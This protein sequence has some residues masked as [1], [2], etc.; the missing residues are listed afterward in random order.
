MN[1][2]QNLE[3][4]IKEIKDFFNLNDDFVK[5][6]VLYEWHNSGKTVAE[7][8]NKLKP[9]T[10]EDIVNFYKKTDAYVYDLS[11]ESIR[12]T[13][14]EW[15]DLIFLY[16]S[17]FDNKETLLDF[18]GGVGT[19]S[20]FFSNASLKTTY[21]DLPSITSDFARYRVKQYANNDVTFVL[22]EKKLTSYD[23]IVC[24][25]VLEHLVDPIKAMELIY[26]KLKIGGLVFL[27]ESFNLIGDDYPSHLKQNKP[28]TQ[29]FTS[30]LVE[31]GFSII[32]KIC[33]DRILVLGKFPVVDLVIPTHNAYEY[34]VECI[35]SV[36][37]NTANVPY[38]F[39]FVN[40]AST[41]NK[42]KKF[43]LKEKRETDLY[44]E[45][46]KNLGFVKT[47]NK[48]ME[49]SLVNDVVLLNTDTVVA[50]NWLS[51][52]QK[53][54]YKKNIY[55]TANPLSNNASIYSIRDIDALIRSDLSIEFLGKIIEESSLNVN[56][57][58]PVGVGFCMYIKRS[59]IKEVGLFDEVFERGYGEESDYC[60]RCNL[61]GYK[62]ILVDC[63]FVYHKG[64]VS[65]L[66]TG[67]IG[68]SND[69]IDA[70]EQ[71]IK[72]RY[73]N[74]DELINSFIDNG[75][76]NRIS[77][78][79]MQNIISL[80]AEKRKKI[81]YVIHSPI[82]GETIGGTEFHVRDLTEGLDDT[83]AIYVLYIKNGRHFI[84][85]EY[86]NGVKTNYLFESP[87]FIDKLMTTNPY[88]FKLYLRIIQVFDIDIVHIQHLINH[89]FDIINAAKS[90]G[91][92]VIMTVHDYYLVSIDYNLLYRLKPNGYFKNLTP[93]KEYFEDK[94]E[95][96]NFNNELWQKLIRRHLTGISLFIFPSQITKDELTKVY[97]FINN[98]SKIIEHGIKPYANK[99]I[100]T[101]ENKHK[102]F[103]VLFLGYV[104]AVQKGSYFLDE[105]I[106]ELLNNGIEVHLLG[107][108]SE[109]WAKYTEHNNFYSHGNYIR[110]D[111]VAILKQINPDLII[112]ASPW[113]ETYSYTYSEALQAQIPVVAFEIGAFIER[114][115]NYG[116]TVLV[117]DVTSTALT[118]KILE[119]SKDNNKIKELKKQAKKVQLKELKDNIEEYNYTYKQILK[120]YPK[121]NNI[122]SKEEINII[123]SSAYSL[124]EVQNNNWGKYNELTNEK[125]LLVNQLNE[126]QLN[127][128]N[129]EQFRFNVKT[130]FYYKVYARISRLYIYKLAKKFKTWLI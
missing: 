96:S 112:L 36:K 120:N 32:D 84:V 115:K 116:A 128:Q 5:N 66:M 71:I 25:E 59:I 76:F 104:N 30:L 109:Y 7:S 19:E 77:Q 125:H 47:A 8:W 61:L 114:S 122:F 28:L 129:L 75:V 33:N 105:V 24:L 58:I 60:M 98:K 80:V 44:I 29:E 12:P 73:A 20:I 45:N 39:V 107:S 110:D 65:M 118:L 13:R 81:L 52:L 74:Y 21:Y 78:N 93:T 57:E 123:K 89:T 124:F 64:H 94:F 100:I 11:V 117:K 17:Q 27:S 82:N 6:K 91:V 9:N 126:L 42:I 35:K 85:E 46:K 101:K 34:V 50:N 53:S 56:F 16:L 83:Y 97:Q 41:D 90:I 10:E 102:K 54:I 38:R 22:D 1:N 15:R 68:E 67:D 18:G 119:L 86:I 51:N 62:H 26:S 88:L 113:P 130:S 23:V 106:G 2:K 127:N 70:H 79:I 95:V 48:G 49:A 4:I 87:F 43:Y 14:I 72:Q 55:A 31:M 63:S 99:T 69:S 40:D 92:P 111:V 108:A 37:T 3:L 121:L 103:S